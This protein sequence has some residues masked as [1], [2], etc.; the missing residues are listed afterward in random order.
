MNNYKEEYTEE[1]IKDLYNSL[2]DNHKFLVDD[3][4]EVTNYED[5][6]NQIDFINCQG[7]HDWEYRYKKSEIGR[8]TLYSQCSFCGKKNKSAIKHEVVPNLQEKINLGEIKLYN[9]ALYEVSGASFNGFDTLR[10]IKLIKEKIDEKKQWFNEHSEYLKTEKW[11]SIRL[12]VLKRDNNLCQCCLES[13]ATEVHHLTYKHWKE[14]FMFELIS[15][16]YNCHH[17]K[18]HKK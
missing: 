18:I 6:E 14:E 17:N 7:D 4:Y 2:N 15:V 16:C 3:N 5:Y 9:D 8:I 1:Q 13:T 12:K 10:K 11:K